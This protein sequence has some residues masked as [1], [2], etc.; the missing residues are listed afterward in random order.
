MTPQTEIVCN[1]CD[2]S[3]Y[4]KSNTMEYEGDCPDLPHPIKEP[5]MK[6]KIDSEGPRH[7]HECEDCK[8]NWEIK[9]E[10]LAD[11]LRII[12]NGA[13]PFSS[14]PLTHASNTIEEMKRLAREALEDFL[15]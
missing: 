7:V 15:K 3:G 14:D 13:G 9:A 4:I 10:K 11:A 5:V 12:S 8:P 2:G 1:F 6:I